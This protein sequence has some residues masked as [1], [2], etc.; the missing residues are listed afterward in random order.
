MF[1]IEKM[2]SRLTRM[3]AWFAAST[4]KVTDFSDG[5]ITRAKLETLAMELEALDLKVYT[6]IKRAIPL[7]VYQAFDFSLLPPI[8]ATGMVT[9]TGTSAATI[10]AGI[11]VSTTGENIQ[12]FVT[13]ESVTLSGGPSYTGTASVRC[14][15][16]GSQGN[17]GA[18]TIVEMSPPI[19]GVT[20]VSNSNAF[21][22]G[23]DGE[24]EAERVIRFRE[25]VAGLGRSTA[26]GMVVGAK[27]AQLV[28][29]S[30]LVTERVTEAVVV[31]PADDDPNW[32]LVDIY[33]FNGADG[34]SADLIA[35]CQKIIDGYEEGGELVAGYKAAGIIVTVA[36]AT[37]DE[38]NITATVEIHPDYV[39]SDVLDACEAYIGEFMGSLKIGQ[40]L[41]KNEIVGRLMEIDGVLDCSVSVPAGNVIPA[42]NEIIRA[43]TV[44]ITAS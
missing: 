35:E 2:G 24:T 37:V 26:S 32:G 9:F 39:E 17:V 31:E 33:I 42:A 25:Y 4:T 6:A 29:D 13:L 3:I 40:T 10:P 8:A 16:T 30:G 20:S 12:S 5:S 44:G 19:T 38:E 18:A 21:T 28:D 43:G 27:T 1:T 34:A 36:A 15:N 23:T 22:T 11:T 14:T 7:S 41:Y